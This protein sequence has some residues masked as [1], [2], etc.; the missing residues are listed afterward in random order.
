MSTPT[1]S[2]SSVSRVIESRSIDRVPESDRTGKVWHQGPLWFLGN[3]QYF[4]ISI[5]FVGPSLGL[6][7]GWTVLA[8]GAGLA[9]GALFMA[10][11]AT[12]GPTL[13]LPQM[14]QSRAQFGY[15]G[16][17]VPLFA[18]L[19]TYLAF[20]VADTVL[21]A[22]GM[23]SS[24]GLSPTLV[25]AVTAVGAAVLAIYG[26]DWLHTVFR[27]LLYIALPVMAVLTVGIL[28]GLVHDVPP[29]EPG[30]A[31]GFS[32]VAFMAQFA[33][34]ASY[35]ITY[36]TYVSD[37]SRYL[38]TNTPGGRVI[39][40][41]FLGAS[42]SAFWLIAVGAWMAIDLGVAD[43]LAGLRLA[44]N[45]IVP[46]LGD[47]AAL[48]S[49]LALWATMGMNAYCA[50][51]TVL[52]AVDSFRPIRPGRRARVLVIIA[53]TVVW[54][55]V[56]ATIDAGSGETVLGAAT[57]MLYLLVPWTAINLLDFFVIR[58]GHYAIEDI[59][60]PRGI[61]GLWAWRGL[62]ACA[63]GLVAEIPFMNIAGIAGLEFSG[64]VAAALGGVDISW[65]V[66]LLVTG[67][68]YWSLAQV[69]DLPAAT[70]TLTE[71]EGD[72]SVENA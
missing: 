45:D 42:T 28:V 24:F 65:L 31:Y 11:H 53:L 26:H 27:W 63:I 50:N 44:G 57:L 38:P 40:S 15:R 13:G 29:A 34:A 30:A 72:K 54:S 5:G 69:G 7:L 36:A 8:A 61:Y 71:T 33:T 18:T 37:Y 52:T 4:S 22:G 64:P 39:A 48:L 10:L 51:L 19:F 67:I 25:A 46:Y 2:S 21:L 43:G 62:L 1:V 59:L 6:S 49:A 35:N 14:I 23:H 17:I 60:Q 56:A 12:Q 55:A 47:V 20:N 70:P 32:W 68:A 41:V 58:R 3:F 9:L 16:V 66:G